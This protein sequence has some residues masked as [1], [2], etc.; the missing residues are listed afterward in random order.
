MTHV[1]EALRGILRIAPMN[2]F[3]RSGLEILEH[4]ILFSSLKQ[5]TLSAK[6]VQSSSLLLLLFGVRVTLEM[7]Y[8][9]FSVHH[10]PVSVV[11][12]VFGG[13]NHGAGLHADL[14]E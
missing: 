7:R 13:V 3:L 11:F 2:L 12:V 1:I 8:C 5:A 14:L 9:W 6:C 4:F 10:S